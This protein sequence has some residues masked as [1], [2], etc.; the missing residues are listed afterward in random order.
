MDR[1]FYQLVIIL[2]VTSIGYSILSTP[3]PNFQV[4]FVKLKTL[5]LYVLLGTA[6]YGLYLT[7]R[8]PPGI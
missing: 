5:L 1:K 3:G 4:D 6:A 8:R 7:F 2:L